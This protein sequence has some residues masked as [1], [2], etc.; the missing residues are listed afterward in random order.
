M[1]RIIRLKEAIQRRDIE[2]FDKDA[3]NLSK[4]LRRIKTVKDFLLV[5]RSYIDWSNDFDTFVFKSLMNKDSNDDSENKARIAVQEFIVFI[6][7]YLFLPMSSS[8]AY[9][10]SQQYNVDY[11]SSTDISKYPPEGQDIL[12]NNWK[13]N[14]SSI[15]QKYNRLR[16]NAFE[17]LYM[18]FD[19]TFS[20]GVAPDYYK[21]VTDKIQG[22]SVSWRSDEHQDLEVTKKRVQLSRLAI[23]KALSILRKSKFSFIL[24][25]TIINVELKPNFDYG[26]RWEGLSQNTILLSSPYSV[27]D[28]E[29][30]ARALIH[31]FGHK[32]WDLM[33]E[34]K[35]SFFSKA[36][37]DSKLKV[38]K[39]HVSLLFDAYTKALDRNKPKRVGDIDKIFN[40][41]LLDS[42]ISDNET[43]FIYELLIYNGTLDT[44]DFYFS[45]EEGKEILENKNYQAL[46]EKFKAIE[47]QVL[48]M[49]VVTGYAKM[50]GAFE[51]FPE[52]F[53]Y[54]L[55]GYDVPEIARKLF[56][57]VTGVYK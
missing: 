20:Q 10:L 30:T 35:Q 27:K 25:G 43:K 6:Q 33:G 37:F 15:Y 51:G 2:R 39:N 48:G 29:E 4:N 40:N 14:L 24:N 17:E 49:A 50:K 46:Y 32:Y 5:R 19:S 3:T 23:E 52:L 16:K 13:D 41:G 28:V 44:I 57:A 55:M 56:H 7:N 38:E 11:R 8:Q 45:Y 18:Y 1:K 53:S 31:E 12:L 54:I 22:V 36:F 21:S 9:P 42:F 47:G 26:G 34:E